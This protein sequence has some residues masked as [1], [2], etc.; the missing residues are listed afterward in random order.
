M[1]QE[2]FN[3]EELQRDLLP[4]SEETMV[5]IVEA[6]LRDYIRKKDIRAGNVL[7]NEGDL[8]AALNVSRGVIREALSRLRMLGMI[9][10]KKKRGT[11]LKNPD[12]VAVFEK[13]MD[14]RIM[15][16]ETLQDLFQL[17]LVLEM[18]MADILFINLNDLNLQQL[19]AIV[20]GENENTEQAFRI[21]NE[22]AFHGKLY[23]IAGNETMKQFQKMLLPIF[24]YVLSIQEE[25]KSGPVNH[26]DLVNLLRNGD[27]DSFRQGMYMHLKPNFDKL[28]EMHNMKNN[29]GKVKLENRQ[30]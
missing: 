4:I 27:K 6:R 13:V 7:P 8:A 22:V 5:D 21:Q 2:I 12:I 29:S 20:D 28:H 14:P 26:A 15:N 9:E 24:E 3:K 30:K 25:F 17:R 10:S 16:E 23:E 19:D 18:G 11:V 1:N